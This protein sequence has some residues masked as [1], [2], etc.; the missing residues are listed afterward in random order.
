MTLNVQLLGPP[1]F[2]L[3]GVDLAFPFRKV[4]G[5][6]C[7]LFVERQASR[8]TLMD[9]FWGDREGDLASRNLRNALYEL[10]K[11]LPPGLI[12][13]RGQQ[14][15]LG[16]EGLSL[17]LSALE[18]SSTDAL[19]CA[20][21]R[22]FMEG[23]SLPACPRFE[24]WL[25]QS[26]MLFEIRRRKA[27]GDH[28][29]RC[30]DRGATDEALAC[31]EPLF[32]SDEA[33]EE[34]GRLLMEAYSRM[35]RRGEMIRTYRLLT[36]RLASELD[37]KPS[38]E[39]RSFY[40][41]LLLKGE[42]GGER[43]RP[44]PSEGGTFFGRQV[45][46]ERVDAFMAASPESARAVFVAGEAGVG[47]SLFVSRALT[48]VPAG[49]LVVTCGAVRGEERHPLL[50]WNDLLEGLASKID[51]DDV[52]FPPAHRSLL[53]ESFPSLAATATSYHPAG[54]FRLGVIM[55]R[56]FDVLARRG[57]VVVVFEDLQW[58][59]VA[60]LDLLESFLVHRRAPLILFAT[61]RHRPGCRGRDLFR[62]AARAD[63]CELMEIELV[64]FSQ[65]ET[66]AF[67]RLSLPDRPLTRGDLDG[68][69]R[70]TDGLP[71]FLSGLIR[72][73]G[74]GRSLEEAP[75]SLAEAFEEILADLSD[76]ERSLLERLSVFS[77]RAEWQLL[78]RFTGLSE[79][80]LT[81]RV[82]GLRAGAILA[83]RLDEGQRLHI[84]FSHV[85][86]RDHIYASLS[87]AR[88]RLL[89]GE[90]ARLL[91]E[92]LGERRWNDLLCSRIIGHCR[93]A[94]LPVEELDYSI[95]R[96]KL[97]IHL[98]YELFP[99]L[100]DDVLRGAS[101]LLEGK[102]DTREQLAGLK[103]LL[104]RLRREGGPSPRLEALEAS[105]RAISGGYRLWWGDY[106]QG[107]LLVEK[108]LEE[109]RRQ[110]DLTLELDALQHLCYY[111]IQIEEAPLLERQSRAL[112]GAAGKKGRETL[113][114]VALRFLGMSRL[115]RGDHEGAERALEASIDRFRT[116]EALDEPYTL[117]TAAAQN[118][119]ADSAHRQGRL[120][121]AL[122]LYEASA[123]Q[124]SD[125]GIFRGLCLFHS[126]G[127]HVAFDLGD[128]EAFDRHLAAATALQEE[129]D[130][131][132]GNG[133]LFSLLAWDAARKG[134]EKRAVAALQRADSLVNALRKRFW[135]ALQ[136]EVKGRIKEIC[137][138]GGSLD[139][140]LRGRDAYF[141][142]ALAHYGAMAMPR[143]VKQIE[144]RLH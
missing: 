47:K 24:E 14:I 35:G 50:P 135:L 15:V 136:L 6:A 55:A 133:I 102:K 91:M 83:E 106:T 140:A 68:L 23:F 53:A 16:D 82:E 4:E 109:A 9:L 59:D 92:E 37:L 3:D 95:R 113:R 142:E 125:E 26:R 74:A 100:S 49:A 10:R 44:L 144:G 130:G 89:H 38:S 60:S 111:A 12:R 46:L 131:W 7:Y 30:L 115:L 84:E 123:H 88:R 69:Y 71:L 13:N 143:K 19:S 75:S 48:S 134:N 77:T 103:E 120:A 11:I 36:D 18:A 138:G 137:P 29:R 43:K 127:A 5:L 94:A 39:T 72:L 17:D 87:E 119:L 45:E 116:I 97:H 61:T 104:R 121:E 51:L 129:G 112:L 20:S 25:R 122:D 86:V 41:R 99:L 98:N 73:L 80:A 76:E 139:G 107:K 58:F 33:D 8:E 31:L 40:E 63:R 114:G 64:P 126:N 81:E 2:S 66:E 117:Q 93:R 78:R 28:G 85:V 70:Q 57:P 67:C 79:A 27:M 101:A 118:Y 62:S 42:T 56:L 22:P 1:R 110:R 141:R 52:D 65:E 90:M 21:L 132:R 108:A 54:P 32:A 96:L 128:E 105:F 124:C 34:I